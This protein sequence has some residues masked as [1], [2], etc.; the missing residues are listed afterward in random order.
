MEHVLTGCGQGCQCP[1]VEG[2]YQRH[3]GVA[4]LSVLVK[5]VFARK[6]DR[7]LVGLRTGVAEKHLFHTGDI[8]QRLGEQDIVRRIVKVGDVCELLCLR[9]YCAY[10]FAVRIAEGIDADAAAEVDILPPVRVKE[11]RALAAHKQDGA[12]AVRWHDVVFVDIPHDFQIHFHCH[13]ALSYL[14][15]IPVSVCSRL[16]FHLSFHKTAAHR[17]GSIRR[18]G[19]SASSL[20]R[21]AK[22]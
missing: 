21:R 22:R 9:L 19:Q 5:A 13:T 10:P 20:Q 6:L 16:L 11:L 4:A 17:A 2:V 12:P 14:G 1:A 15:F 3:Y 18:P 7:A 8:A